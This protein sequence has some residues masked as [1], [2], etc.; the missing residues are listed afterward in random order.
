MK[1]TRQISDPKLNTQTKIGMGNLIFSLFIL[2]LSF[3]FGIHYINSRQYLF[4]SSHEIVMK[5]SPEKAFE[6]ISDF[7]EYRKHLMF[8][9]PDTVFTQISKTN[10]SF[11]YYAPLL[12]N[13]PMKII[14]TKEEVTRPTKDMKIHT[15]G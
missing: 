7:K 15:V 8:C 10:E 1:T 9:S 6:I 12:G 4:T 2:P 13:R 11:D 5:G 3:T 14:K